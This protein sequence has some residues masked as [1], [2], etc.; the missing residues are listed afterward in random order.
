[1]KKET[2]KKVGVVVPKEEFRNFQE[3]I[4]NCFVLAC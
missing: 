4:E 2:K 3:S 1:M